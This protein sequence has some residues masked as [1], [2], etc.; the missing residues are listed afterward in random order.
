M[1]ELG[2]G[3][4]IVN[5]A[6]S[7]WITHELGDGICAADFQGGVRA[8]TLTLA[9]ELATKGIRVNASSRDSFAHRSW[10]A[11]IL[12]RSQ[13]LRCWRA[14]ATSRMSQRRSLSCGIEFHYGHVLNVDG[15]F[16]AGRR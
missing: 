2:R 1:I 9:A 14:S 13:R 4:S 8:L 15:G 11:R 5:I 16:V 12:S 7:S 3:G 10:K 6:P